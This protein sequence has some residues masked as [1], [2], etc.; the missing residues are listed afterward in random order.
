VQADLLPAALSSV[1]APRDIS[2]GTSSEVLLRRPDVLRAENLLKA[3][4]A[5]IGA[6]RA[7]YFPRI[8][9]SALVGSASGALSGLFKAGTG[10][11]I[12]GADIAGPI[13]DARTGPALAASKVEREIAVAQYERAIQEA[14]RDVADALAERGT[15]GDQIEAQGSLVTAAAETYRLSSARYIKGIDSYLPVLDAQRSLYSAQQGLIAVRLATLANQVRLYAALGGG[16]D[17]VM[18]HEGE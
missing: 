18:P 5:N 16:G 2:P 17:P 12:Y 1:T 11:W 9:L 3:A 13:F 7:A 10:A 6:A 8:S 4:N 14:F 15:L